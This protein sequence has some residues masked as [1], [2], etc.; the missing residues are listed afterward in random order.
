MSTE[1]KI[2]TNYGY[3]IV[4]KNH[5]VDAYQHYDYIVEMNG[6]KKVFTSLKQAKKYISDVLYGRVND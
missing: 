2:Y 1:E 4:R 3:K 5:Y 6:K